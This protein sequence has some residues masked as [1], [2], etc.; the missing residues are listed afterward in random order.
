[1]LISV[2]YEVAVPNP[3]RPEGR[4]PTGKPKAPRPSTPFMLIEG[5]WTFPRMARRA[6]GRCGVH[7]P[8]P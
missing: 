4:P 1:M 6:R 7:S 2:F 3:V 5:V 8:K